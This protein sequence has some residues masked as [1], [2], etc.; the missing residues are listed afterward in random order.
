MNELKDLN[1]PKPDPYFAQRVL[2]HAA[3]RKQEKTLFF[4][5]WVSAT[6][7][8]FGCL[9]SFYFYT[10]SINKLDFDYKKAPTNKYMVLQLNELPQ[11]SRI[12]Y[13]TLELDRDMDFSLSDPT[14]VGKKELT[15][16]IDTLN[17]KDARLPFVFLSR[18]AGK[19]NVRIKFL[20][21]DFNVV[22]EDQY[23]LE[24]FSDNK[25]S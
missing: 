18:V 8:A 2:A 4:W 6:S 25:K 14:L 23:N 12:V 21:E 13:V 5:K 22:K 7:V 20:D 10:T 19:K 3:S 1:G 17:S 15:I 24:F 11:D 16:A 9:M